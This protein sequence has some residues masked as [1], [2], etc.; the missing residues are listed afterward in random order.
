LKKLFILTR[1]NDKDLWD[2]IANKAS[3]GKR[4]T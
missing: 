1:K 4:T 2:R 3:E